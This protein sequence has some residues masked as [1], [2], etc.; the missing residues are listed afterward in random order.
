MDIRYIW[1]RCFLKLHG[2]ALSNAK[3]H[4]TCK[5]EAGSVVI[6]SSFEKYSFC[7]YNCKI[8]DTEIGSF[9]SIADGVVIG[10]AE[11]PIDWVSSSPVFYAGRDSVKKKFSVFKREA[12]KKTNIGC[13]VWIGERAIIKAGVNIGTGAV[14]AMGAVVTKDIEP[15]EI[16]GGVPA[17]HIGNRFDDELIGKL[18]DSKWWEMDEE[19]LETVAKY[20]REPNEFIVEA[21]K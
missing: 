8:I 12:N 3:I 11:H 20:V 13:D 2:V 5:I 14:I 4:K 9:C 6:N 1:Q 10:G 17:R 18:L 16:V 7:G 21:S 15:Y 19:R